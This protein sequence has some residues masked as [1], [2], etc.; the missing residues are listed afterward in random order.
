MLR[1]IL[2]YLIAGTRGGN[3]RAKILDALIERP[4]NANKLSE[5]LGLDYKTVKHH[6]EVLKK[7]SLIVAEG[8]KYGVVYFPSTKLEENQDEFR[9]ILAIINKD[10]NE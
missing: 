8:D 2:W 3:S 7:N 1:K 9:K 6:L 5:I 10:A 4:Y